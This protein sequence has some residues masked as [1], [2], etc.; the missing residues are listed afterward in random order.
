MTPEAIV[1]N[2]FSVISAEYKAFCGNKAECRD[3]SIYN[4]SKQVVLSEGN[5]DHP[6]FIFIGEAPGKDEADQAKPFVGKA[7]QR[8]R[9]EL[10][11]HSSIFS[12]KNTLLTNVIPCRPKNNQFPKKIDMFDLIQYN[13]KGKYDGSRVVTHCMEKWLIPELTLLKPKVIIPLGAIALQ[14]ICNET[15]ITACRGAWRFV[16]KY[17]A[18]AMPTYHPSYVIR[19][20]NDPEKDHV[21]LEFEE[22]IAKIAR[23]WDSLVNN[24]F[25]MRLSPEEWKK[26]QTNSFIKVFKGALHLKED[27]LEDMEIDWVSKGEDD[28]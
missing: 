9:R 28:G 16:P 2:N 13:K 11:K 15:G 18:W 8:L 1:D 25:R 26:F 7:G 19:C 22:D 3:C 14:H 6:T 20:E 12:P 4:E 23:T 10:R 24:D 27:L 21:A 17:R 5:G